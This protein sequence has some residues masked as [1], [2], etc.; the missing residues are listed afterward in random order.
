MKLTRAVFLEILIFSLLWSI[1]FIWTKSI[2]WFYV[3]GVVL[4]IGLAFP[5]FSMIIIK[6]VQKG[7][8]VFGHLQMILILGLIYLIFLTPISFFYRLLSKKNS[9][10]T[11]HNR[12]HTFKVVDFEKPW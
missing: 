10:D 1:G 11:W 3:S 5:S 4:A 2:I 7:L 6:S 12:H 9:I 8:S